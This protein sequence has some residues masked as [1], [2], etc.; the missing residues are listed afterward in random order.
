MAGE[1][2][3]MVYEDE[4]DSLH[5]LPTISNDANEI[6]PGLWLGGEG[7]VSDVVWLK[8]NGISRIITINAYALEG[9]VSHL[10]AALQQWHAAHVKVTY[11][12]AL[13]TPTQMVVQH[14]GPALKVVNDALDRG[15]K[16]VIHCGRGISRSATLA[17]TRV[18]ST[19]MHRLR[20][21]YTDAF[22]LVSAKRS[23]IYPNVGFQLQLFLYEK[24]GADP[25]AAE[26][27]CASFNIAAEVMISIQ[28]TL[29]NVEEQMDSMFNDDALC[30]DAAR[31][32]DYGFFFQNCREYLGH[33][34]IGLPHKLMARVDDVGRRLRNLGLVFDGSGVDMALRVG[35]VMD[36][37]HG[38][39]ARMLAAENAPPRTDA[40]YV[41]RLNAPAVAAPAEAEAALAPAEAEAAPAAGAAAGADGAAEDADRGKRRR[42]S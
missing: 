38:L 41:S 14:F 24:H 17:R 40:G 33:V 13:D 1:H 6:V 2:G 16:V 28:K 29:Q 22:A 9:D 21:S 27:A 19:L 35:R 30:D 7:N 37:W 42:F 20:L 32:L 11:I 15:E 4:D 8:L 39:T 5:F 12:H 26:K 23:C 36:V 31:W 10:S 34:D 3:H 18:I 25:A